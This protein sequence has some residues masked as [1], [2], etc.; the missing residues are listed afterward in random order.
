MSGVERVQGAGDDDG[1]HVVIAG[2][3]EP[4]LDR[5]DR[6]THRDARR[7]GCPPT[8]PERSAVTAFGAARPP[9]R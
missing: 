4:D 6:A 3:L 2:R 8:A 5:A 7:N 1:V 9:R